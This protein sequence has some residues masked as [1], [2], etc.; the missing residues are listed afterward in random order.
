MYTLLLLIVLV[1]I[2]L[3]WNSFEDA[4]KG[5][6]IFIIGYYI[7]KSFSMMGYRAPVG[8]NTGAE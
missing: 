6:L 8:F 3:S 2:L 7:G 1:L 5:F 4:I